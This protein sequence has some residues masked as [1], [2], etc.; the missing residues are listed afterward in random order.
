MACWA[1]AI[2]VGKVVRPKT[3]EGESPATTHWNG[4][5]PLSL[6]SAAIWFVR[7]AW[8]APR[9]DTA[10]P[11]C[12]LAT[13]SDHGRANPPRST[14]A[15]DWHRVGE[16]AARTGQAAAWRQMPPSLGRDRQRNE[17]QLD[18][19]RGCAGMSAMAISARVIHAC[20][21][22]MRCWPPEDGDATLLFGNYA[23]TEGAAT[24]RGVIQ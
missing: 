16:G 6:W 7:V 20:L 24:E 12:M 8:I 3:A 11:A 1:E 17:Q 13:A 18:G 2:T 15:G 21:S 14:P 9:G 19:D 23:V 10:N 4:C 22:T 5:R